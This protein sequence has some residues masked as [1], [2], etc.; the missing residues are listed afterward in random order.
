MVW[1]ALSKRTL[2][3]SA[4][5]WKLPQNNGAIRVSRHPRK[6]FYH[7]TMERRSQLLRHSY[8]KHPFSG[9]GEGGGAGGGTISV[10][11]LSCWGGEDMLGNGVQWD[12][13]TAPSTGW[14]LQCPT[15]R[16]FK[17]RWIS[18]VCLMMTKYWVAASVP[19]CLRE[20]GI[21]LGNS[22]MLWFFEWM[23]EHQQILW[24]G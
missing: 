4:R 19:T 1:W 10:S 13:K 11:L 5:D 23:Y 14:N 2:L 8:G 9:F 21:K 17:L 15:G 7:H 16:R 12:N 20:L 24:N 18:P 6:H 3:F 22:K